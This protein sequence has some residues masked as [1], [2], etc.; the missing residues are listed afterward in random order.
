MQT[1]TSPFLNAGAYFQV[2]K[3]APNSFGA[4]MDPASC[5]DRLSCRLDRGD[6][7]DV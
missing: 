4:I 1:L 7:T 3:V 6:L 2:Q 5:S